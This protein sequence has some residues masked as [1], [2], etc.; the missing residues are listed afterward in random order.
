VDPDQHWA[1]R[2]P[3]SDWSPINSSTFKGT[4]WSVGKAADGFQSNVGVVI[5]DLPRAISLEDY[6]ALSEK[7]AASLL[8]QYESGKASIVPRA[9][10]GPIGRIEYG[11]SPGRKLRFLALFVVKGK[12]AVIATYT[13]T[14]A[15]YPGSVAAV[16]KSLR[17]LVA[18]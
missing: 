4:F 15:A 1:M 11:A 10:G 17:T 7:N 2:V 3:T 5:E 8:N 6:L 14:P 18:M 13:S 9:A 16:E 12:R